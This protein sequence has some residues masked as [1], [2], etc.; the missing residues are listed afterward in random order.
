[1]KHQGENL[2]EIK[3]IIK[4]IW[5]SV[6][7]PVCKRNYKVSEIKLLAYFQQTYMIQTAC[8]NGHDLVMTIYIIKS[9]REKKLKKSIIT[10]D[11]IKSFKNKLSKFN[12]NFKEIFEDNKGKK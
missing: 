12:G 3:N 11:E 5:Q 1:M 10:E 7:C 9:G 8:E 2:N 4:Q 6:S